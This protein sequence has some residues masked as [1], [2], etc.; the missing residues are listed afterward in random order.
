VWGGEGRQGK[1]LKVHGIVHLCMWFRDSHLRLYLHPRAQPLQ[2]IVILDEDLAVG[3]R[4]LRAL[5]LFVDFWRVSG[6][7]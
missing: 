3:I 4:D 1:F 6:G 2:L 7:K 5:P